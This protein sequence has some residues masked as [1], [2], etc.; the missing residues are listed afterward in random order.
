M[1]YLI[2]FGFFVVFGY[3]GFSKLYTK[4][5]VAPFPK[6]WRALLKEK[7]KFYRSLNPI[8]RNKFRKRVMKFLAETNVESVG[9][10]MEDL[11]IL[12]VA[13]SAVIPTL[14][15]PSWRYRN[16]DTV[17]VYPDA[18]DSELEFSK[19][20]KDR[21]I[22]GMVG[23][24]RLKNHMIL[25]RKSLRLGFSNK[26]SKGNTGVH[27][28]VHL[29][30]GEDGSIDGT[31]DILL[32]ENYSKPWISLMHKEMKKINAGSSDIRKYAATSEAE[33]FAVASVYFF[34]RPRLFR[35]K[36]PELYKILK[37]CFSPIVEKEKK[38]A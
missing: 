11:D 19:S 15:F 22:G 24:G 38:A 32:T 17:L 4:P 1:I 6:E 13:A 25:S 26:T 5:K 29:I 21:N 18:F 10:E 30:D 31:P 34:K 37:A 28:F 3:V 12:L 7:V 33:F 2:I 36:H 35:K 16:L 23:S 27:E 8:K 14:N 9:F 20:Q